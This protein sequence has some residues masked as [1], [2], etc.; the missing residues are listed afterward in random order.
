K[1]SADVRFW[2]KADNPFLSHLMSLRDQ[3]GHGLMHCTCPLL[4]QSGQSIFVAFDVASGPKRTWPDALHMSAF[5]PKRTSGASG[6]PFK[7]MGYG[8]TMVRP[9]PRG[10]Q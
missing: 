2:P 6:D 1:T 5:D 4:T 7:G 9:K 10:R 8:G 3:S